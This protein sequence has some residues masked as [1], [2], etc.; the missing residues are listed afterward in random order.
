ME[1]F[2]CFICRDMTDF[3]KWTFSSI[4]SLVVKLRLRSGSHSGSLWL[5]LCDLSLELTLNCQAQAQVRLSLRLYQVLTLWLWKWGKYGRWYV[6]YSKN[7]FFDKIDCPDSK[8]RGWRTFR[9]EIRKSIKATL[10]ESHTICTRCGHVVRDFE[11]EAK[12]RRN[13]QFW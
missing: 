10:Q 13:F 5:L 6:F 4:Q 3:V 2:N 1:L 7:N 9:E 8:S 11:S 12:T